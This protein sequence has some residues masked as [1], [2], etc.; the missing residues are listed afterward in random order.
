[1][2]LARKALL[3]AIAVLSAVSCDSDDGD[4][5]FVSG[6]VSGLRGTGL[7]LENNGGD[8]VTIDAD[9]PFTFATSLERYSV[10]V[11]MQPQETP[12]Q[13]CSVERGEGSTWRPVTNIAVTCRDATGKFLYVA[14]RGNTVSGYSIDSSTGALT[15]IRGSPFATKGYPPVDLLIDGAG[16]FL[17]VVGSTGGAASQSSLTGYAIDPNT[18][19]LTQVS[20]IP[21]TSP[22]ARTGPFALS[23]AAVFHPN[24]GALY[25]PTL[26]DGLHA[27]A[28][29]R[30]NG[31]LSPVPGMPYH[32][33]ENAVPQKGVF[34]PSG[35][36]MFIASSTGS[37]SSQVSAFAVDATTG[38]LT[39]QTSTSFSGSAGPMV[40]HP[41]GRFAYMW[42]F[43][44]FAAVGIDTLS[45]L[46][47]TTAAPPPPRQQF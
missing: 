29:D 6:T 16:K 14:T 22:F 23:S 25:I 45:P 31:A 28:I 35:S 43:G 26:A 34:D 19:A 32:F 44:P 38:A 47:V 10:T 42:R 41:R 3:G 4:L 5:A 33:P 9:G 13:F 11:R 40:A 15:E 46:I 18:G 24:D 37:T 30:T 21:M 27:Y 2:T 1:M 8:P 7:V 17:F 39:L 20:E 36:T 12:A